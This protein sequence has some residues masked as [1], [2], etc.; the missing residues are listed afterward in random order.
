MQL[1]GLL[2]ERTTEELREAEAERLVD[3]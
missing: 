2:L 1:A 3:K